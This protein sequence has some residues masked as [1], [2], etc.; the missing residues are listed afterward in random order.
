MSNPASSSEEDILDLSLRLHGLRITVRGPSAAALDFVQRA[1]ALPSLD[2]SGVSEVGSSGAWSVV[3]APP[4][5]TF[6]PARR[7]SGYQPVEATF[8]AC[9]DHLRRLASSLGLRSARLSAEERVER[10]WTAGCWAKAVIEG[11]ARVPAAT[12]KS[13]LSNRVYVVLRGPQIDP[14]TLFHTSAALQAAVGELQGSDTVCH[15]F[16]SRTEAAIYVE[17]AGGLGAGV[18]FLVPFENDYGDAGFQPYILNL[19]E[20]GIAAEEGSALVFVVMVRSGGALLV[21]PEQAISSDILAAGDTAEAGDLVG[22]NIM[23]YVPGAVL[24]EDSLLMDPT[25]AA[26]Q[27]VGIV[28]VDFASEIASHLS[29]ASTLDS[30]TTRSCPFSFPPLPR[31]LW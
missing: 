11:R 1:S 17:A 9:P 12:P 22:P 26:A 19:H 10:A 23:R 15:G 7:S 2:S 24:S 21:L 18:E 16:P 27:N 14:P 6:S 25:P 29:P 5:S 30:P 31:W 13:G 28:M 3:D 8:P 20:A 4:A